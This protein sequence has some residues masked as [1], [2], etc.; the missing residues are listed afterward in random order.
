MSITKNKKLLQKYG[1]TC[2]TPGMLQHSKHKDLLITDPSTINQ[3]IQDCQ[4]RAA[5]EEED[6]KEAEKEAKKETRKKIMSK[7][8]RFTLLTLACG[9][10]ILALILKFQ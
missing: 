9:V 1:Y 3:I 2:Q 8:N 10:L 4:E 5:K 6:K 7:I